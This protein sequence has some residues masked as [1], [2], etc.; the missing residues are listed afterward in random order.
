MGVEDLAKWE[1]RD[2]MTQRNWRNIAKLKKVLHQLTMHLPLGR[3]LHMKSGAGGYAYPGTEGCTYGVYVVFSQRGY[4]PLFL[5]DGPVR[6]APSRDV[7][8]RTMEDFN[9]P[10]HGIDDVA[11]GGVDRGSDHVAREDKGRSSCSDR[12][13]LHRQILV[14]VQKA[15][16]ARRYALDSSRQAAE[17]RRGGRR[18]ARNEAAT[19]C[20]GTFSA[21]TC[22][23]RRTPYCATTASGPPACMSGAPASSSSAVP[24]LKR[25]RVR[26]QGVASHHDTR[27]AGTVGWHAQQCPQQAAV[28]GAPAGA[29]ESGQGAC[30]RSPLA[31]NHEDLYLIHPSTLPLG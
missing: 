22:A 21:S 20:A 8:S 17:G 1:V 16:K 18:R 29:P 28:I 3:R 15:Q 30:P 11:D 2:L 10:L 5:C 9:W 14:Q 27:R 6:R 24:P 12:P 31:C 25:L 7:R 26:L 13:E 4:R 23:K 19:S